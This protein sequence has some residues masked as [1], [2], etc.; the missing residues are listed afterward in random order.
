MQC[1]SPYPRYSMYRRGKD[2]R[3]DETGVSLYLVADDWADVPVYPGVDDRA[4]VLV[5]PDVAMGTGVPM[6]GWPVGH[7]CCPTAHSHVG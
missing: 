4:E 6:S 2:D 3:S 7:C 5:Y 1:I